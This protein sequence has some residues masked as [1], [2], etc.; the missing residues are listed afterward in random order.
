VVTITSGR[1]VKAELIYRIRD[2]LEEDLIDRIPADDPA[3][4]SLVTRGKHTGDRTGIVLSVH[5]D[6]PLGY[7]RGRYD[8][9]A[10]GTPREQQERP[11]TWPSESVGGS[12]WTLVY[13]GIEVRWVLEGTSPQ[14]AIAIVETVKRRTRYVLEQNTTLH[15]LQDDYGDVLFGL[16]FYGAYGYPGGGDN[17]SVDAHW[18]DFTATVATSR[19]RP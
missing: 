5:A 1:P 8:H 16:K 2:A 6:H 9:I 15:P 13:G 10:E 17:V 11:N 12:S 14:D 18:I 7:E 4:V 3:R 19:P